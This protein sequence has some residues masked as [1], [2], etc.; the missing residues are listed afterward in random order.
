MELFAYI[1]G[2]HIFFNLKLRQLFCC[3][4]CSWHCWWLPDTWVNVITGMMYV[5]VYIC[6]CVCVCVCVPLWSGFITCKR[7]RGDTRSL[8]IRVVSLNA[9][10]QLETFVI[11][12]GVNSRN[13]GLQTIA[14]CTMIKFMSLVLLVHY[15]CECVCFLGYFNKQNSILVA[16]EGNL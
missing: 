14:H 1:T 2:V 12:L 15:L 4:L 10:L 9:K 11:A 13:E 5:Y 16:A 7:F 6:V 3:G 8:C